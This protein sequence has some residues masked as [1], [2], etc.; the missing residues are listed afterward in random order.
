MRP[1]LSRGDIAAFLARF[2]NMQ[3]HQNGAAMAACLQL[4]IAYYLPDRVLVFSS[5]DK[6]AERFDAHQA[7][8]KVCRVTRIEARHLDVLDATTDRALVRFEWHYL[9]ETNVTLRR[10]EVQY[11]LCRPP[12]QRDLMLEMVD[13]NTVAFPQFMHTEFRGGRA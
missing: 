4:P 1:V 9:S 13:Y 11:V 10:S 7:Y 8:L 12:G 6:I 5:R 2:A 3:L